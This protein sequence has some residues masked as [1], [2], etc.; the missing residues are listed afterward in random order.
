MKSK[1]LDIRGNSKN[2]NV[3]KKKRWKAQGRREIANESTKSTSLSQHG[4]IR[5]IN[6]KR[7]GRKKSN[8]Y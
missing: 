8:Y 4:W 7:F 3:I 1:V 6:D 2:V 5:P